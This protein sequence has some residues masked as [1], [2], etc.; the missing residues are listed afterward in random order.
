MGT[1]G[2]SSGGPIAFFNTVDYIESDPGGPIWL[3]LHGPF[4]CMVT[5]EDP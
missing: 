1:H 4:V 3:F 5:S 2:R